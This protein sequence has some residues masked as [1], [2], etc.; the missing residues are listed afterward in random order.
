M[1]NC[2]Q[3]YVVDEYKA[4]N[5]KLRNVSGYAFHQFLRKYTGA[6]L[7]SLR[8]HLKA[9]LGIRA[10]INDLSLAT[11]VSDDFILHSDGHRHEREK[12]KSVTRNWYLKE[13]VAGI[14]SA[15]DLELW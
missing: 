2:G 5:A 7:A 11:H 15:E 1:I 13:A 4:V 3:T 8:K 12:F 6:E 14:K 9:E 10:R